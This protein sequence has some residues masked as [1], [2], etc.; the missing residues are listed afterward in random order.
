MMFATVLVALMAFAVQS[1][2]SDDKNVSSS[3]QYKVSASLVFQDQ[4]GLTNDQVKQLQEGFK[5]EETGEYLTD[6][7][8]ATAGQQIV[9]A[10]KSTVEA[11]MSNAGNPKGKFTITII[12][13]KLSSNSQIAKWEIV[14][15]N[16]SVSTN[17]IQK[18]AA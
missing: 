2:G 12:V 15:D 18:P 17:T 9:N 3:A 10:T 1:C 13:T 16:G 8:A 7:L 5:R 4:A 14:Y 11:S 6:N